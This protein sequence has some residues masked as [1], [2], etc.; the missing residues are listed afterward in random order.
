MPFLIYW[1][2]YL[3]WPLLAWTIWIFYQ[4]RRLSA[5]ILIVL[6]LLFIWTR[7]VEPNWLA[8]NRQTLAHTGHQAKIIMFSDLHAGIFS[9]AGHVERVV[10]MIKNEHP[11][12]VLIAGDFLY[13]IN[14]DKLDSVMAPLK[15]LGP[16][17]V[18]AVL[19]NHD[20]GNPGVDMSLPLKAALQKYGV[21]LVDNQHWSGKIAGQE[22][23]IFGMPDL[24]EN[25][26]DPYLFNDFDLNRINILIMHNPDS[27][28]TVAPS[29]PFTLAVA[30][31]THGGQIRIPWIYKLAIPTA[32]DFD[33]GWYHINGQQLYVSSGVGMV[34]LPLRFLDFP[35]IVVIQLQ[36]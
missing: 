23:N 5:A 4:G 33:S 24:W 21:T 13:R 22:A 34:S 6:L 3:A 19:G 9:G 25:V 1:V 36:K 14:P 29:F 12:A 2:S 18:F 8:V 17:P 10:E 20:E 16:I 35:E 26:T 28:Y 15:N 30:G 27:I 32:Y 11:D 7:F 31:H